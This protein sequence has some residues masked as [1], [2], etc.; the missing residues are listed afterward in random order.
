M[1]GGHLVDMKPAHHKQ[2]HTVASQRI[3]LQEKAATPAALPEYCLQAA[4]AD[5]EYALTR[6]PATRPAFDKIS[7]LL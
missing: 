7:V 4:F 2:E 6:Q 5:P 3:P 1:S